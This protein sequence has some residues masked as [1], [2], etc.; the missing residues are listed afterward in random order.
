DVTTGR[1]RRPL[2]G[3]RDWVCTVAFSPDGT[4]IASGSC[5]WSFHRGHDWP[6]PESRGREWCE[7]RLWDAASGDL[8]RAVTG[9]G[10]LLSLAFAPDG[11]SLACGMGTDV[12]LYDLSSGAEGRVVARH[13]DGVASFAFSPDGA[14]LFSSG[15]DQ[16]V[17]CTSL[18]TGRLEWHAPGYLEQVNSVALSEDRSLLATGS[19]DGR[20]ASGLRE[21]GAEGI[22]PG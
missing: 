15:H 5:D 10:Q 2:A 11:K 14:A 16:A 9:S 13:H 17:K 8:K 12:R 7:W 6:R 21:A 18:A 3:R 22:G 4:A 19:S 20:F 1:L